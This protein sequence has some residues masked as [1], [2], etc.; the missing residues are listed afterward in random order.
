MV[1]GD[2]VNTASRIQSA[3][4]PGTVLTGETTKR[5]TE[6]TIAYEDAG[7]HE[8]KGK[9]EA[10]QLWRALRVVAEGVNALTG[11][12]MGA[13][14]ITHYQRLL[15]YIKPDFVH[16]LYQGRIIESGGPELALQL[17]EQGYDPVIEKYG[18]ALAVAAGEK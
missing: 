18:P 5:A 6:A 9:T 14:V 2:L 15:N 17:E 4:E 12:S 16:I 3:A 7:L 10:M 11:P 13:I 8:M 1:A